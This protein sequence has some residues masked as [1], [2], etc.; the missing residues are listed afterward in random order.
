MVSRY[1]GREMDLGA[2]LQFV[3]RRWAEL[4]LAVCVMNLSWFVFAALSPK[5]SDNLPLRR[6]RDFPNTY[7]SRIH[8]DL[9]S[10]HQYVTLTWSGPQAAAQ[11]TG[12]F[13][14]SPG[15]GWGTNNCNDTVESNCADSQCTPKGI[16]VVEGFEDNLRDVPECRYVTWIDRKREIGFHSHTFVPAY[17]VSHGCVRLEANAARL[18]HDNAVIGKTEIVIDGTW[19][20]PATARVEKAEPA[21]VGGVP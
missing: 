14:S 5:Q 19:A 12:P 21:R 18:M 6:N 3:K 16:R 8:L 7:I 4:A 15:A 2:I 13:H 9:S 20:N 11:K 10:P 17:P 1:R